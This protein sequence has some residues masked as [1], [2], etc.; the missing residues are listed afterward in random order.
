MAAVVATAA[1]AAGT[2]CLPSVNTTA[3]AGAP[4]IRYGDNAA[5]A[6]SNRPA[7]GADRATAAITAHNSNSEPSNSVIDYG[8]MSPSR[9]RRDYGLT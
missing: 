6:S 5:V 7:A 9:G 2:Q 3:A 8:L 1:T 4:S